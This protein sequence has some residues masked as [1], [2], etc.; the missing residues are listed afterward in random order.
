VAQR[1]EERVHAEV[2]RDTREAL[3][4]IAAEVTRIADL[5]AKAQSETVSASERTELMVEAREI[6]ERAEEAFPAADP[7]MK[8]EVA[9]LAVIALRPEILALAD[10]ARA[11]DGT[12]EAVRL[13]E[14]AVEAVRR[15]ESIRRDMLPP[16]PEQEPFPSQQDEV[17]M[18][19]RE[20][21][22]SPDAAAQVAQEVRAEAR[23]NSADMLLALANI[24]PQTA[25][26]LL[27][28]T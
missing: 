8:P 18:S 7:F 24:V 9:S 15:I 10:S 16:P 3:D 17:A 25:I 21:I 19:E 5:A 28:S 14:R 12:P 20:R 27:V 1:N 23:V 11:A 6:A 4:R 13:E 22:E 2:V 26:S